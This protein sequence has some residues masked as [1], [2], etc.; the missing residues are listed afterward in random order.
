M[1]RYELTLYPTIRL[2][3]VSMNTLYTPSNNDSFKFRTGAI[4]SCA[5]LNMECSLSLVPCA[6]NLP[7]LLA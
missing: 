2:P 1:C 7:M 4:S 3:L 6:M 5:S